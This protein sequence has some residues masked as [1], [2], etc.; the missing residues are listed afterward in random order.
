MKIMGYENTTVTT[1]ISGPY[2]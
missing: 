2:N 1:C